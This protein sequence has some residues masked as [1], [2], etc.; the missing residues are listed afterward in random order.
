M[1]KKRHDR[2][3]VLPSSWLQYTLPWVLWVYQLMISLLLTIRHGTMKYMALLFALVTG[4]VSCDQINIKREVP[5]GGPCT[6]D[7]KELPARVIKI[8]KE[9]STHFVLYCTVGDSTNRRIVGP[10]A[11]TL[12]KS[13]SLQMLF[14]PERS[15]FDSIKVGTILSYQ[16]QSI[17]SGSCNPEVDF[18]RLQPYKG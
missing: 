18:L 17:I 13:V 11:D 8:N 15:Y 7:I 9:D 5:D 10:N 2:K 14:E 1:G 3:I 12:I 16:V 6:Y 4:V